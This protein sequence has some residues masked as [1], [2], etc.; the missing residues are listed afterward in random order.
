MDDERHK[1]FSGP[2]K[3]AA[4]EILLDSCHSGTGTRELLAL[5]RQPPELSVEPRFLPPL[6][7]ILCRVDD[8]LPA[9]QFFN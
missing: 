4:L 5:E 9:Q 6:M 7:D 8:D 2:P 1:V 3:G